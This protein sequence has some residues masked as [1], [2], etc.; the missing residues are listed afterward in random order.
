MDFCAC[1]HPTVTP[2]H[3]LQGCRFGNCVEIRFFFNVDANS[4]LVSLFNQLRTHIVNYW[5]G[6]HIQLL[7]IRHFWKRK[8]KT[9][10]K[11]EIWFL[12]LWSLQKIKW[13]VKETNKQFVIYQ[14]CVSA[15][16][17]GIYLSCLLL[18]LLLLLFSNCLKKSVTRDKVCKLAESLMYI[19]LV[20]FCFNA[21]I[22][23]CIVPVV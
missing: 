1:L 2:C 7:K 23:T 18:I 3:S 6:I 13:I 20:A 4:C 19:A 11:Y 12:W 16:N 14:M 10:S 5:G 15:M 9:W 22:L 21:A 8:L 17:Y